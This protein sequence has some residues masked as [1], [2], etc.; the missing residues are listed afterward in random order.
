MEKIKDIAVGIRTLINCSGFFR[1]LVPI[2]ALALVL[3]SGFLLKDLNTEALAA[4][5]S[6]TIAFIVDIP[7][8]DAQNSVNP[9]PQSLWK[10]VF[11]QFL[12]QEPGL[13]IIPE[14][15]SEYGYVDNKK[16]IFEAKVQKGIKFH[17]G[18][19]LTAED[20]KFSLDASTKNKEGMK[21]K[22]SRI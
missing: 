13:K 16:L 19:S 14:V 7:S 8:W 15:L 9:N 10:C 12:S 20:V 11:D 22:K 18:D 2:L 5:K 21:W 6:L 4:E 17:N 1:P 3:S